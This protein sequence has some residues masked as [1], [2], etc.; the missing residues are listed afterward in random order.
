MAES[1]QE[2]MNISMPASLAQFVERRVRQRFGNRSEYIRHLIRE[3]EKRAEQERI[4]GM[5]LEGLDSGPARTMTG[6]DW[7]EIRQS[8]LDR[9]ARKRAE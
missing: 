1:A 5:L 4:E 8:V 3:D 6:E 9:L 7:A 2:N